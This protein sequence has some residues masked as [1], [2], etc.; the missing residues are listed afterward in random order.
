MPISTE[1]RVVAN[2]VHDSIR[3]RERQ[4]SNE[5]DVDDGEH[6]DRGAESESENDHGRDG[7][8]RVHRERAHADPEVLPEIGGLDAKRAAT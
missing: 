1:S 4:R 6:R 2:H 3:F 5:D 8:P 7:E